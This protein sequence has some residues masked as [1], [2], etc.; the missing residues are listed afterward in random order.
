MPRRTHVEVDSAD[1]FERGRQRGIQV[2]AGLT[3]SWP[4]YQSLFDVTAR[5]SAGEQVD[6]AGVAHGCL[7]ALSTWSPALAREL[8]GVAAGAG[9]SLTTVMALNARTEIL[10]R[11]GGSTATECST[12]AQMS[13]AGGSAVAA[14]TWDWHDELSNGWH[15][16]TVRGDSLTFVGLAEFA[17]LAKIGVNSAGLAIAFNLLRHESDVPGGNEGDG[18][19]PGSGVPVHLLARAVLGAASTVSEA[20]EMVRSAP[21]GASTVFTVVTADEAACVEVCPAG[22]GVVEPSDGWLVHT[23]H[24]LDPALAQG[25]AVT[26]L[27]TTTFERADLLRTRVKAVA[28]P[29]EVGD[30]VDLLCAHDET[31]AAVCRHVEADVEHGYR[32]ATLATVALDPARRRA[33]VW[34]GGP[35]RRTRAA[36]LSALA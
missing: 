24:F 30:L 16:Q 18:T 4:V 13:G 14:Q 31:G 19:S 36:T 27:V 9:V 11:A 3:R 5:Q 26:Q 34:E 15:V 12:L 23:N 25:E 1:P 29:L 32:T 8:E 10:A 35:C 6:V 20:V 17:M 7:D 28:E 21:I 33:D 2:A 22:V